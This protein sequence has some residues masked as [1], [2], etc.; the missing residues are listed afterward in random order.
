MSFERLTVDT[1]MRDA[2]TVKAIGHGR[3][4]AAW[5]PP[6]FETGPGQA[7]R[8]PYIDGILEAIGANPEIDSGREAFLK[9]RIPYWQGWASS[10]GG[11]YN[12]IHRE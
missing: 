7:E 3:Y 6:I 2:I 11:T 4:R 5:V 9:R 1:S 10:G 8:L 12:K